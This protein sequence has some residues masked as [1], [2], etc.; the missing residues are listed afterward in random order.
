MFPHH[1][2]LQLR[3]RL[4]AW[5]WG[6]LCTNYTSTTKLL[7]V[8]PSVCVQICECKHVRSH[9]C[10]RRSVP[11]RAAAFL[12]GAGRITV[13]SHRCPQGERTLLTAASFCR[14]I[15]TESW[16]GSFGRRTHAVFPPTSLHKPRWRAQSAPTVGFVT[17]AGSRED[18]SQ[19]LQQL[20]KYSNTSVIFY[21]RNGG[22]KTMTLH[23]FL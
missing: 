6:S 14:E 23:C 1:C 7:A 11:C 18:W 15:P 4:L 22:I 17:H 2:C 16:T 20:Q 8:T 10:A 5:S 12:D 9:L 21:M 13:R 19:H 3:V